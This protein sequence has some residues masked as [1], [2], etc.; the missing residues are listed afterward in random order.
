MRR[1]IVM[2]LSEE[3]EFNEFEKALGPAALEA[4]FSL[5]L[6]TGGEDFREA[7]CTTQELSTKLIQL[8]SRAKIACIASSI[9]VAGMTR[10]RVMIPASQWAEA[11][12]KAATHPAQDQAT[13]THRG[14]ESKS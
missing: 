2:P 8:L 1:E 5:R 12:Q 13:L 11:L 7:I 4:L 14:F 9:E 3:K 10:Y 6:T